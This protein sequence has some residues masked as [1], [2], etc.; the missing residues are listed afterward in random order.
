LPDTLTLLAFPLPLVK[1]EAAALSDLEED[2]EEGE[3]DEGVLDPSAVAR[4]GDDEGSRR[5]ERLPGDDASSRAGRIAFLKGA[6]KPSVAS[7]D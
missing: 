5:N 4:A 1:D 3:D 7:E 2:D 6:H